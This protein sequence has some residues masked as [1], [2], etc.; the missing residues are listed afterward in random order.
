MAWIEEK[1]KL[2]SFHHSFIQEF[3]FWLIDN[4]IIDIIHCIMVIINRIVYDPLLFRVFDPIFFVIIYRM[5]LQLSD[6]DFFLFGTFFSWIWNLVFY[7]ALFM[8]MLWWNVNHGDDYHLVACVCDIENVFFF[9]SISSSSSS[10][11]P[12]TFRF[13]IWFDVSKF[14]AVSNNSK[15]GNFQPFFIHYDSMMIDWFYIVWLM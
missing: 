6:V 7:F 2:R 5:F 11:H 10:L 8:I 13:S 1:K 9:Y 15:H 12:D 14:M 3:F 4:S